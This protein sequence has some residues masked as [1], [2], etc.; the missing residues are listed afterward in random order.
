MA[1]S[2]AKGHAH[3]RAHAV[4][5]LVWISVRARSTQEKKLIHGP[6][7]PKHF[8][9]GADSFQRCF[10]NKSRCFEGFFSSMSSPLGKEWKHGPTESKALW[11]RS[12]L[13]WE[14]SWKQELMYRNHMF[15]A[16]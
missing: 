10:G 11:P 5:V 3:S 1:F 7:N 6:L 9:L 15:G 12:R 14:R 4:V 8:G 2:C 16:C 13:L